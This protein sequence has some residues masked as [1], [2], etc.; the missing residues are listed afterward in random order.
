M[1]RFM[2]VAFLSVGLMA[3]F[4]SAA[5]EIKVALK[6]F[7]V[8]DKEGKENENLG[9]NEADEKIF[10]YSHGIAKAEVKAEDEGEYELVF[11]ASCDEANKELAKIKIMIGDKEVK[12][13]FSLTQGDKK[14]YKIDVKLTKGENKLSFEFLNDLY[15]EG[16]Y[17]LNFYLHSAKLVKKKK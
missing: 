8:T 17:D 4:S 7:K 16:E 14:E 3:G 2:L 10:M 15:K 13:E 9:F 5:D 11:E 6:D 1:F 12:K